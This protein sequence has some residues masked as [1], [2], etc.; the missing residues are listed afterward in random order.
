MNA[1]NNQPGEGAPQ[2]FELATKSLGRITCARMTLRDQIDLGVAIAKHKDAYPEPREFASLLLSVLGK[3]SD[4]QGAPVSLQEAEGLEDDELEE[5]AAAFLENNQWLSKDIGAPKTDDEPHQVYLLRAFRSHQEK[6]KRSLGSLSW[7]QK[8]PQFK[9]PT[10]NLFSNAT[11]EL[12]KRNESISKTL[13]GSIGQI[14]AAGEAAGRLDATFIEPKALPFEFRPPPNPVHDTNRILAEVR[15][16]MVQAADLT[17]SLN[18]T[19]I[20]MARDSAQYS[21]QIILDSARY[22]RRMIFWAAVGVFVAVATLVVTGYFNRVADR[23]AELLQKAVETQSRSIAELSKAL[24]NSR[25][26]APSVQDSRPTHARAAAPQ[27]AGHA[28]R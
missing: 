22:S 1:Q 4:A 3:R 8:V 17:K 2:T 7:M 12:L 28:P 27:S 5:F 18:D 20:G 10:F 21:Q 24:A 13:A 14:R 19:T 11:L 23:E 25:T 15:D 9:L 26:A 6:I 16:V